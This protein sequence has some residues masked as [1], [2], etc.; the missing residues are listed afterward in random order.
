[1]YIYIY[2]SK[3]L[4][5]TSPLFFLKT[6]PKFANPSHWGL[7]PLEKR[8]SCPERWPKSRLF[9]MVSK[10]QGPQA[11]SRIE[12]VTSS[13]SYLDISWN[14]GTPSHHPFVHG[15]V[16]YKPSSYGVHPLMETPICYVVFNIWGTSKSVGQSSCSLLASWRM[17][18]IFRHPQV[19]KTR[20]RWQHE[21]LESATVTSCDVSWVPEIDENACTHV[22]SCIVV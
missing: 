9:P 3:Y 21:A 13:F 8:S 4:G 18:P 20:E 7:E 10:S 15:I 12:M 19:F 17:D 16:P 2:T 22:Y 11:A 1:M 14:R 5:L 6:R